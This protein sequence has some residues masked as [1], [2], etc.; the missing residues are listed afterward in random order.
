MTRRAAHASVLATI[1]L[2][3]MIVAG[4][5]CQTALEAGNDVDPTGDGAAADRAAAAEGA[6]PGRTCAWDAPFDAVPLGV[7][8]NLSGVGNPRLSKDENVLVFDHETLPSRIPQVRIATRA[9]PQLEPRVYK[10][11][12]VDVGLGADT[13]K[14][15]PSISADGQVLFFDVQQPDASTRDIFN[16]VR[17]SPD[18]SFGKAAPVMAVNTMADESQPFQTLDGLELYYVSGGAIAV[19]DRTMSNPAAIVLSV[20]GDHSAPVLSSDRNT[21][22][23]KAPDGNIVVAHRTNTAFGFDA[24]APITGEAAA[25][26]SKG[27]PGWLSPDQCRLYFSE[28]GMLYVA[29]R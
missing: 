5:A 16:A 3:A 7:D 25:Q 26:I 14:A 29:S 18:G 6:T 1:S 9:A 24:A 11:A 22:Y 23:L 28:G 19:L 27:I 17:D 13:R 4:A 2:G 12:A 21:I 15:R 10:S 8:V 20:P